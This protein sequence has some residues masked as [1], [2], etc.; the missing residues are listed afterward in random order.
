MKGGTGEE[1]K[2]IVFGSEG[3]PKPKGSK[4][5]EQP[6]GESIGIHRLLRERKGGGRVQD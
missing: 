2:R 1:K 3:A 5:M 4:E 6:G